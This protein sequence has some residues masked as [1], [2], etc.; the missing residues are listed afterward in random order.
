MHRSIWTV[1]EVKAK[2]ELTNQNARNAVSGVVNVNSATFTPLFSTTT[3][4]L[5]C[6]RIALEQ[7]RFSEILKYLHDV[8]SNFSGSNTSK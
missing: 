4:K 7:W 2:I 6:D 5:D 3:W 8:S 1:Y